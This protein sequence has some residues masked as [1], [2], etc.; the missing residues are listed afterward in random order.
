M[1][2]IPASRL[3]EPELMQALYEPCRL[4]KEVVDHPGKDYV[5]DD[6]PDR[7][8]R[9]F[10]ESTQMHRMLLGGN[11][12]GKSR[13][14]AQEIAWWLLEKHPYQD[15]PRAPK[16][17]VVSASYTT[18]EEGIFRHLKDIIPPWE[19]ARRGQMIPHSSIPSYIRCH[20]GGV[21]KFISGTGA[22]TAR[23][24]VQAAAVDLVAIDEEID[25]AMFEELDR[26]RLAKGAG[27]IYSLTAVESVDW[28]LRLEERYEEGDSDVALF[29]LNS[30]RA[31]ECGHINSRVLA[32]IIANS[33]DE[34]NAV[35]VEGKTFRRQGQIYPEFSPKN[36]VAPFDI[37]LDWP[38]YMG[39]DPGHNV[40]AVLWVA[41]APNDKL[42]AYREIYAHAASCEDIADRIF[43]AEGW[44]R[45][46]GW[47]GPV[48]GD[49][50]GKWLFDKEHSERI[51]TRWI[52]P[53]EFGTNPGGGMKVGNLLASGYGVHCAPALNDVEVGIEMVK[54]SLGCGLDGEPRFYVWNS[55]VNFL[56]E[57][58]KYRRKSAQ[59]FGQQ[60]H[61]RRAVPVKKDDHLMDAWRYV[62]AGGF[63][64]HAEGAQAHDYDR[65]D[66]G[67][68]FRAGP[69]GSVAQARAEDSWKRLMN[70]IDRDHRGEASGGF[71]IGNQF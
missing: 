53:A 40:F 43:A 31:A 60:T 38:R 49:Y 29:R 48:D 71:G 57:R 59:T 56:K 8:Q 69:D 16:I 46:P 61:E 28:V 42:Y 45:N 13:A 35:R 63:T 12:S 68:P 20:G 54:R 26:R 50:S 22:N 19:I 23:R 30:S 41:M 2:T 24:K 10:H 58:A 17:W 70:N 33:S 7:N 34:L 47:R 11:Q 36:I 44:Q 66:L 4:L 65:L 5:P 32:D 14:A 27:G 55:C 52:D 3:T 39:I 15:T 6:S 67:Y 9:A 64:S 18:I 21:V 1:Q 37:P 51:A 62:M 25:D